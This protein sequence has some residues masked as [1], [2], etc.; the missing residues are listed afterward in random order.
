MDKKEE[1]T[2]LPLLICGGECLEWSEGSERRSGERERLLFF[3]SWD[4]FE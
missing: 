4:R 3:L 1:N 2:D